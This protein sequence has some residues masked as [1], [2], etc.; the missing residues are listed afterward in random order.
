MLG[1][2][3]IFWIE[4][5]V[6][7]CVKLKN[8]ISNAIRFTRKGRITLTLAAEKDRVILK[9]ADTGCGIE[10]AFIPRLFEDFQRGAMDLHP[11]GSGLGLAIAKRL[12]DLMS[13]TIGVESTLGEGST[14]I[15]SLPRYPIVPGGGP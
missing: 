6:S 12:V 15:V 3:E 7:K 10:P 13:G 4:F 5:D 2:S 11:Q 8:L 14:F 1:N 9:V